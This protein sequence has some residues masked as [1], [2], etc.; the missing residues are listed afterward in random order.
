V[1]AEQAGGAPDGDFLELS[2]IR[3]VYAG[4]GGVRDV[5]VGVRR[6]EMLVLLGP[7]GCGKTTLLRSIAGLVTPQAGT[8]SVAGRDI[9]GL[10]THRRGIG[11]VFQTWALFPHMTVERNVGY[12][13][14]MR[15]VGKE[16]ERQRIRDALA[17]VQ[18]S[19]FESRK[20]KQLSGG[21]QQRVALARAIVTRPSVLLL[22]EPL[23][24]LDYRIR[25]SLRGELRRLQKRLALT[26]VY[27]TH[28][29]S[30][31][32]ALGDHIAVMNEGRIV[33]FGRP[34]QVFSRPVWRYT[35]QFLNVGNLLP[36][37]AS[38]DRGEAT[39]L[40]R[41]ARLDTSDRPDLPITWVCLPRRAVTV[42]PPGALPGSL[43]GEVTAVEYEAGGV[44]CTVRLRDFDTE[45]TCQRDATMPALD[46]GEPVDLEIDLSAAFPVYDTEPEE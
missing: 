42:A 40:G 39:V 6:G 5:S 45:I 22:D 18:M 36:A 7:S 21:Q 20:P 8:V 3:Q 11:M 27:V 41:P 28:D 4:G 12:G 17:M 43:A 29:Y 32:L 9:T 38:G 26:G 30:E 19:G 46:V 1:T 23:S 37:N 16:E 35:A 44:L 34:Q 13:L 14:R 25:V 2:G 15:R 10:P 33:E 31:A 24:S